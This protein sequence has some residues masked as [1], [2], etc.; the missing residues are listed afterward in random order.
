MYDWQRI[1]LKGIIKGLTERGRWCRTQIQKT[2]EARRAGWWTAKR[3]VGECAREY[4]LAYGLLRGVPYAAMEQR[5]APG[6]KDTLAR[7][8]DA[9]VAKIAEFGDW[10]EKRAWTKDAILAWLTTPPTEAMVA[11]R[12]AAREHAL[13]MAKTRRDRSAARRKSALSQEGARAAS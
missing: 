6:D 7:R 10:Q 9:L 2:R 12:K 5:D 1:G 4:H 8:A 13:E 11:Q 3:A